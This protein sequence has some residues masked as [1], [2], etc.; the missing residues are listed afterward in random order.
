MQ[1]YREASFLKELYLPSGCCA[2]GTSGSFLLARQP[3]I[4]REMSAIINNRGNREPASHRSHLMPGSFL[5]VLYPSNRKPF[6]F[7]VFHPGYSSI[8]SIHYTDKQFACP[9][10]HTMPQELTTI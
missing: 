4:L 3:P 2:L 7:L 5:A 6:T 9:L 8:T 1:S 10:R